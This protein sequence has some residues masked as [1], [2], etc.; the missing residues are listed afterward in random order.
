MVPDIHVEFSRIIA[1][2][3]LTGCQPIILHDVPG[4]SVIQPVPGHRGVVSL[5]VD[6]NNCLMTDRYK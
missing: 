1:V 4:G 5:I 2:G 6:P 3:T